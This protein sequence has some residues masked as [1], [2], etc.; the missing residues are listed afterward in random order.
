M[1][2]PR[3]RHNLKIHFLLVGSGTTATYSTSNTKFSLKYFNT[4]KKHQK[5][6]IQNYFYNAQK[7][8]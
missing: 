1:L 6:L 3:Y 8:K 4:Y 5:L 7:Y 2:V